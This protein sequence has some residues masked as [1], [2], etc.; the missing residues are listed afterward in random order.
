MKFGVIS[1]LAHLFDSGIVRLCAESIII[2]K[3]CY[4]AIQKRVLVLKCVSVLSQN[5]SK[6]K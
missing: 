1:K 5:N 6:S 3:S 4:E 2:C